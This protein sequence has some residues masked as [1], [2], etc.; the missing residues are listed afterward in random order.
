MPKDSKKRLMLYGAAALIA[1]ALI[2]SATL[3]GGSENLEGRFRLQQNFG[4]G[5]GSGFESGDTSSY[6]T[7]IDVGAPNV[8]DQN[9]FGTG[10]ESIFGTGQENIYGN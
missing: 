9:I 1:I 7:G 3:S 4:G 6:G 8:I 2:L 10:Q 5:T